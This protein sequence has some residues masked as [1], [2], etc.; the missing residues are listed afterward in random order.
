MAQLLPMSEEMIASR[1]SEAEIARQALR[2]DIQSGFAL[3]ARS[4]QVV[5][6]SSCSWSIEVSSCAQ[7]DF[8]CAIVALRAA[9]SV[10]PAP[11]P[12]CAWIAFATF[13]ASPTMP[14]VTALVR[15]IRFGFMSTWMIAACFGQ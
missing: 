13:A 3:R 5:P 14:T 6:G 7:A 9:R 8:V 1:G 12:S 4:F 15:P 2:G 10:S 11:A